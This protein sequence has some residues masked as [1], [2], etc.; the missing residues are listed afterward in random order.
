V[1]PI[2]QFSDAIGEMGIRLPESSFY[3]GNCV[4]AHN[5]SANREWSISDTRVKPLR[6][7]FN[8]KE[9]KSVEKLLHCCGTICPKR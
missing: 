1:I 6:N 2:V 9:T 4:P 7:S 8:E 5:A 3:A